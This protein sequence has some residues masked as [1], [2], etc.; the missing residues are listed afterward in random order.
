GELWQA[1]DVSSRV[2]LPLVLV[3]AAATAGVGVAAREVYQRPPVV[4]GDQ[5]AVPGT[6]TGE[7]V[8]RSAQPGSGVVQLSVDASLHPEGQ[9][10]HEVLQRLFDSINNRDYEL[11]T[12]AVTAER[13][14]TLSRQ[15]W[16]DDYRTSAD[17]SILVHRIEVVG[18]TRLR[19]LMTLTST[20]DLADAPADLQSDCIE[21]RVVYPLEL[22]RG[23]W[24]VD[25]GT[26]GRSSQ[27]EAC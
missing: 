13:V 1:R 24:R 11:W 22:E 20:Q 4:P 8:P 16:L 14:A 12:K 10:V 23:A 25:L 26:E 19:V 7:S 17:G 15:K 6:G 18:P 21:W 9:R 27:S 2:L 3:I 5:I